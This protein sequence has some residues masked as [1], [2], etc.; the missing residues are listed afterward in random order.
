MLGEALRLIRVFHDCK[1]VELALA[2]GLSASHI[3]E[4]EKGKRVPSIETINKYA[5]F[6]ETSPSAI[7]FFSEELGKKSEP[8][9]QSRSFMRQKLIRF[10]QIVEAQ[11]T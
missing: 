2:L 11:T 4:I 6:F 1:T 7:L 8:K 10:L 3:S 5:E 9:S